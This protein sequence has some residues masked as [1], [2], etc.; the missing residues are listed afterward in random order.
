MYNCY[1]NLGR[2]SAAESQKRAF[3]KITDQLGFDPDKMPVSRRP[4]YGCGG[5]MGPAQFIPTTWLLYEDKVAALTG[6]NPP[7]PWNIEDAFTASAV[8]LGEG[9]AA[10]QTKAGELKAARIYI[11]G[12]AT[13]STTTSSGRACNYYANRVFSLSQDIDRVI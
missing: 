9:G 12:R 11:S 13:C 4:S 7:N 2:R 5:A 1:I 8:F 6:H 3:L 10:A